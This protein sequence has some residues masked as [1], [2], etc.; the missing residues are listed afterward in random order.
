MHITPHLHVVND[1][2]KFW[3]IH[4]I[5]KIPYLLN[6]ECV[7]NLGTRLLSSIF[8]Y[9]QNYVITIVLYLVHCKINHSWCVAYTSSNVLFKNQNPKF[10]LVLHLAI[11]LWK[12]NL[13]IKP[14]SF[15][16]MCKTFMIILKS[17]KNPCC[18]QPYNFVVLHLSSFFAWDFLRIV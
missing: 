6:C 11:M 18:T 16:N 14:S 1:F 15:S 7:L 4:W 10:P 2:W 5:F 17:S 3:K 13:M 8:F 9:H 12:Q